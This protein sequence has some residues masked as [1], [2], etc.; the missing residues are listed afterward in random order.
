MTHL[1]PIPNTNALY[2]YTN[3]HQILLRARTNEGMTRPI[4][5]A[6]D[7]AGG[8]CD[9]LFQ[10]IIYFAY[11]T[12][13]N[14]LVVKNTQAHSSFYE[15]SFSDATLPKKNKL[16]L[17]SLEEHLLLFYL[18]SDKENNT[19]ALHLDFPFHPEKNDIFYSTP[20]SMAED[21]N[22]KDA[23]EKQKTELQQ[24]KDSLSQSAQEVAHYQSLL[25]NS[26]QQYNDLM[27]AAEKYREEAIKWRSKFIVRG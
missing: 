9:T 27:Y 16:Q 4:L 10:G 3:E 23:Y 6:S 22:W 24:L 7:Y 13:N 5:L 2:L 21:T 26:T 11:L 20:V 25:A 8:L 19:V 1:Y 18:I 15:V 12:K 17:C 14:K